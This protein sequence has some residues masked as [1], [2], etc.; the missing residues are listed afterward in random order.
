M[1]VFVR[2]YLI[3]S[4]C[5]SHRLVWALLLKLILWFPLTGSLPSW[6]NVIF[7]GEGEIFPLHPCRPLRLHQ[8]DYRPRARLVLL[9]PW[10]PPCRCLWW[11]PLPVRR[12]LHLHFLGMMQ[13]RPLRFTAQRQR[14][15]SLTRV[16]PV[17]L[18]R[19]LCQGTQ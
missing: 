18:R 17:W 11:T 8:G 6:T 19:C 4:L 2:L 3:L 15:S 7:E 1:V 16:C 5:L 10:V 12:V 13:P 14:A 9:P